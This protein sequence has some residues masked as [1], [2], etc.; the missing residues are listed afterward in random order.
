MSQFE[1]RNLVRIGD[2]IISE[3]VSYVIS[4]Q[5]QG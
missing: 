4:A 2:K 5:E 1:L 3:S